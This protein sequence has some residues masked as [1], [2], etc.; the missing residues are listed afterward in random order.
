MHI[1]KAGASGMSAPAGYDQTIRVNEPGRTLWM[2][3][4]I[5]LD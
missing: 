5:A 2:K 4:Q 1:S 3:A